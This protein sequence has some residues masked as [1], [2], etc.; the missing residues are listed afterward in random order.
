MIYQFGMF[1]VRG[2][3]YWKLKI[4]GVIILDGVEI[5]NLS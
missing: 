1:A 5:I 4:S 2:L 3:I